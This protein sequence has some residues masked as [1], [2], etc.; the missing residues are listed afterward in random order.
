MN[1]YQSPT[2]YGNVSRSAFR[3]KFWVPFRLAFVVYNAVFAVLISFDYTVERHV[4]RPSEMLSCL[5]VTFSAAF[6]AAALITVFYRVY[7]NEDG[8]R[9]FDFWGR[10]HH[11]PWNE[12]LR[13]RPGWFLWLPYLRLYSTARPPIW[14][15]LFLHR[16]RDFWDYVR[17][18]APNT[19]VDN[20]SRTE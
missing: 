5:G 8:I 7:T 18:W 11:V 17:A 1:P 10:Y 19:P 3:T 16:Q 4:P 2:V 15:P 14:V 20:Y 13:V 9:C 12:V 6:I